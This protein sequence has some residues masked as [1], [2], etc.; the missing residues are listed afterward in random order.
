MNEVIDQAS[1]AWPVFLSIVGAG[2]ILDH[3]FYFIF[4]GDK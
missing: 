2:E 4:A 1:K 3:N